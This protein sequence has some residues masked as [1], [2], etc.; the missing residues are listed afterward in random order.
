MPARFNVV[1]TQLWQFFGYPVRVEVA[2][3]YAMPLLLIT[4]VLFG[5]QRWL[6]G[7]RGYVSLTGKGG[8]RRPIALGPWRWVML[9]YALLLLSLSVLLP[10][11]CW[12]RPRSPRPGAA[13]SA[14]TI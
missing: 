13:A 12:C 8:E 6:I 1:T 5:V 11:P 3:A 4:V 2:A 7:R 10:M 9:G 14:S